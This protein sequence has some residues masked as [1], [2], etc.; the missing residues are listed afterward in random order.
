MLF[1]AVLYNKAV[2]QDAFH[3]LLY[4]VGVAAGFQFQLDGGDFCV[5]VEQPSCKAQ[6]REDIAR[7]VFLLVDNE[8]SS[9]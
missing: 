7:I 1:I 4:G 3:F 6:W 8:Y 5:V 2:A 9:R